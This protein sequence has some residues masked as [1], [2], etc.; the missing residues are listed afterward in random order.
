MTLIN[1]FE[2]RKHA[3]LRGLLSPYIDGQVTSTERAR[4]EDHLEQCADCREELASLQLMVSLLGELPEIRTSRSFTLTARPEPARPAFRFA[5]AAKLGASVAVVLLIVVI[6]TDVAGLLPVTD[7]LTE[8]GDEQDVVERVVVKEVP[9]EKIA[10]QEIIKEVPVE[11]VVAQEVVKEVPVVKEVVK[12]IKVPSETVIKEVVKEVVVEK[13]V[14]KTIEIEKPVEVVK[15]VEVEKQVEVIRDVTPMPPPAAAM[16][17][18]PAE[19][20]IQ[21]HETPETAAQASQQSILEESMPSAA[22]SEKT[23]PATAAPAPA[24]PAPIPTAAISDQPDRAVTVTPAPMAQPSVPT[25]T[26][27][28]TA[29]YTPTAVPQPSPTATYTPTA[30]PQPSPTEQPLVVA[31]EATAAPVEQ[32]SES[33][34]PVG[35]TEEVEQ[36]EVRSTGPT[37]WQVGIALGV[38]LIALASASGW[39]IRHRLG[40]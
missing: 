40:R 36:P 19:V 32:V 25:V 22:P 17:P 5:T 24:A 20:E 4:L 18:A 8:S 2:N 31:P 16:A 37:R 13:E 35:I 12:T 23:Q 30:V 21:V 6:L 11:N 3:R 14:V 38:I 28:P 26:P 15:T 7:S 33:S 39:F 27:S 29:T 9:V 10:T 34:A 1:F